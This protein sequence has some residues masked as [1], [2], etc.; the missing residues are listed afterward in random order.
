MNEVEV[1]HRALQISGIN[2]DTNKVKLVIAFKAALEEKGMEITIGEIE[3]IGKQVQL[4]ITREQQN[5]AD[6][7]GKLKTMMAVPGEA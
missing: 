4:D 2:A 6:I 3:R 7:P 1:L 5:A